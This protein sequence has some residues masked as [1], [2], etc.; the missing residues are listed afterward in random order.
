MSVAEHVRGVALRHLTRTSARGGLRYE[1][2]RRAF[3]L[4]A[5]AHFVTRRTAQAQLLLGSRRVDEY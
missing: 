4:T 2:S 5:T 1:R 3:G